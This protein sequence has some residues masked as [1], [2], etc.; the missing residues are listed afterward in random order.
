MLLCLCRV[1][2]CQ[3]EKVDENHALPG[4]RWKIRGCL[5]FGTSITLI[6]L[7]LYDILVTYSSFHPVNRFSYLHQPKLSNW[8]GKFWRWIDSSFYGGGCL[9]NM[10]ADFEDVMQ[11]V[12]RS[13]AILSEH[14]SIL[15]RWLRHHLC[16]GE[17]SSGSRWES[18]LAC[19]GGECASDRE[20]FFFLPG[21]W[22]LCACSNRETH[23]H[24]HMLVSFNLWPASLA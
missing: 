20:I 9:W 4:N 15:A 18:C 22:V 10:I 12:R 16:D 2:L 5:P 7:D 17:L 11:D 8:V 6:S 14:F 21:S 3:T 1:R 23:T 13:L 19:W 24:T